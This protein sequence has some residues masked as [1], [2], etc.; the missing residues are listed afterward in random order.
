MSDISSDRIEP[1][2]RVIEPQSSGQRNQSDSK[3]R[4]QPAPP[5][6]EPEPESNSEAPVHQVDRRV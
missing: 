5:R 6:E 4:R 1:T 2:P 3:S